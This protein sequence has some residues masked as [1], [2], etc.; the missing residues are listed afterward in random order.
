MDS[1]NPS[2]KEKKEIKNAAKAQ[3]E[4]EEAIKEDQIKKKQDEPEK[5]ADADLKINHTPSKLM[6]KFEQE[7]KLAI[8]NAPIITTYGS[9]AYY[10]IP[11]ESARILVNSMEISSHVGHESTAAIISDVLERPIGFSRKELK[12]KVGQQALIFKLKRR[13]PEGTILNRE[14][15]EE[16]GYEFGI[17]YRSK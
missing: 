7:M 1:N 14:Q 16:I 8:I 10:P 3:L 4:E 17:L 15:L 6:P 5:D 11:I 9:Y 12:Q 13:A 2:C